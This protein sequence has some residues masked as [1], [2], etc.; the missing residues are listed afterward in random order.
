MTGSDAPLSGAP[1]GHY[2]CIVTDQLGYSRWVRAWS[3]PA[4][5]TD[6]PPPFAVPPAAPMEGAGPPALSD[7]QGELAKMLVELTAAAGRESV[8]D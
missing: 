4:S 1:A 3:P 5:R 2:N 8:E 6:C 7:L